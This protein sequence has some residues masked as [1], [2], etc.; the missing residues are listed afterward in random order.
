MQPTVVS[1]ATGTVRLVLKADD[2]IEYLIT[3]NNPKGEVFIAAHLGREE[4][5]GRSSAMA[6]LF[7]DVMLRD[8][9]LQ[10]RGSVVLGRGAKASDLA[11]GLQERPNAF[12]VDVW[13]EG[14]VVRVRGAIE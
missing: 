12:Y 6:T 5:G 9:Y 4:A 7:S 13:A 3:L 8:R 14:G 2:T 10:L 11:Q 1:A